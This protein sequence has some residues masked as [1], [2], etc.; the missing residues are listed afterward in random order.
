MIIHKTWIDSE[1]VQYVLQS[2][3]I[4]LERYYLTGQRTHKINYVKAYFTNL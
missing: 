2:T 4:G 1:V 3:D